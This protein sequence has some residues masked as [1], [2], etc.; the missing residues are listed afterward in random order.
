MKKLLQSKVLAW[1]AFLLVFIVIIVSYSM[2]SAWWMFIDIFFAFLATFCHLM[3]VN[4]A[5]ISRSASKNLD[6]AAAVCGLLFV[7][8]F[9]VEFIFMQIG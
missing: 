7:L 4:F 9:I 1:C 6:L 8:S 2:R 5:K 3:A